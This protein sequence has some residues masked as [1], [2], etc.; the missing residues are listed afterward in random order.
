M[1]GCTRP[2]FGIMHA[3][4]AKGGTSGGTGCPNGPAGA[5]VPPLLSGV[6]PTTFV[7]SSPTATDLTNNAAGNFAGR[8]EQ[9]TLA[10]HLRPNQQ[11]GTITYLD[12][13]GDSYYHSLQ[14]TA[15]KRFQSGLLFGVAYTFSKSIDDQSVDPVGSSSGGGLST[16]NS[17]TPAD[18]RTWRNERALS[19]F[20]RFNTLTV[21]SV[22]ELPVGKGKPFLSGAHGVLNQ[23]IGGWSINGIFT[24]MSGEP[25]SIR[26]GFLTFHFSHQS[27]ADLV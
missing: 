4:V 6:V 24:G 2:A 22:Y 21:S 19:D 23:I 25:F 10:A 27:R 11:F 14:I 18:T 7:N 8:V 26:S 9:T 16:S 5:S 17:R 15:R 1:L 13:G 20:N 3:K 12:S